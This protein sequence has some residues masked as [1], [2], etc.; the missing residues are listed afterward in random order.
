M[1]CLKN[2]YK[3]ELDH[4]HMSS[5]LKQRIRMQEATYKV[6]SH[7]TAVLRVGAAVALCAVLLLFLLPEGENHKEEPAK[8]ALVEK[9][10]KEDTKEKNKDIEDKISGIEED[11]NSSK[12]GTADVS[13][14][15][16]PRVYEHIAGGMG[17]MDRDKKT[18]FQDKI[19][20]YM[21]ANDYTKDIQTLPFYRLRYVKQTTLTY[22]PELQETELRKKL[23]PYLSAF[24]LSENF[25]HVERQAD[26]SIVSIYADT[27]DH[28]KIDTLQIYGNGDIKIRLLQ[29]PLSS[30]TK[31][32]VVEQQAKKIFDQYQKLFAIDNPVW[33]TTCSIRTESCSTQVYASGSSNKEELIHQAE[34]TI[35]I[36]FDN[37]E[38]STAARIH[39]RNA[40][41]VKKEE[42]LPVMRVKEAREVLLSGGYY[43][44]TVIEK[45]ELS[46]GE[47]LGVQ[48]LYETG[49]HN[50]FDPYCIPIYRFT[51]LIDTD[52]IV[53]IDVPAFY[54]D[55]LRKL[56]ENEW[57]FN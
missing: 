49:D 34:Q 15:Y 42:E 39:I 32:T 21:N 19:A 18:K 48:L 31:E 43:A 35:N 53:Q 46:S 9:N 5:E 22:Q 40:D 30:Y 14:E 1:I 44:N 27:T 38:D 55:D 50:S 7:R 23:A 29:P 11:A 10:I 47:E 57:Y 13:G 33:N 37:Y 2:K 6:P 28:K 26:G 56:S 24:D 51:Y 25:L 45:K 12:T 16:H 36:S 54:P 20:R 3:E 8:L 41:G 52:Y 17:V 4:I